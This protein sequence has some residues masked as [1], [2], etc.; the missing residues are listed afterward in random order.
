MEYSKAVLSRFRHPHHAGRP[1]L[2]ADQLVSG[3]AGK[4]RTGSD[5]VFYLHI[6][7]NE[8]RDARFEAY[9]C[10]HTIAVAEYMAGR[11]IG[12]PPE[13]AVQETPQQVA[14]LLGLPAEKLGQALIVEDAISAAL[15]EWKKQ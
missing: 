3:H 6:I 12:R 8:I 2:P 10:P 15:D 13:R 5:V 1:D 11:L 9:G 14:D 4:R 7:A